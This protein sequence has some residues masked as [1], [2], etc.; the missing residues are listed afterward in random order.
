MTGNGN[1]IGVYNK[2]FTSDK[3]ALLKNLYFTYEI[4]V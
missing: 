3:S 4:N 2:S 1:V